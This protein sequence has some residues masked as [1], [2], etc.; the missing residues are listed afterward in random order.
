MLNYS[1][2]F[3]VQRWATILGRSN[4]EDS[5]FDERFGVDFRPDSKSVSRT[6]VPNETPLVFEIAGVAIW[7]VVIT[8]DAQNL[9]RAQLPSLYSGAA[10]DANPRFER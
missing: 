10:R 8:T 2:E 5:G 1:S 3:Y 6:E 7:T 9:P 4:C